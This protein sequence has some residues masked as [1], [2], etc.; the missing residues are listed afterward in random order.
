MKCLSE[1]QR[2]QAARLVLNVEEGMTDEKDL[3]FL[4]FLLGSLGI[5]QSDLDTLLHGE[6][7]PGRIDAAIWN[8]SQ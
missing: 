6:W 4:Y 1:L 7:S 5:F 3:D 8:E 2:Y